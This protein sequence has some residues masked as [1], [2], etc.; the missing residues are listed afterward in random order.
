MVLQSENGTQESKRL[1]SEHKKMRSWNIRSEKR[2]LEERML[3]NRE[4]TMREKSLQRSRI[5]E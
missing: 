4:E 5:R 2:I 1:Y 3:T